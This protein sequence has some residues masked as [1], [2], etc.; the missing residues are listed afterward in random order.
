MSVRNLDKIFNPQRIAVVGASDEPGKVGFT[1][2]RN[3]IGAG[4]NGVVYPINPHREAVQGIHAYPTIA[5]L[6]RVPDLAIICTPAKTVPGLIRECGEAG[7]LGV[8]ILSAGFREAGEQGRELELQMREE[9]RQFD[10][11]R[12]IGPNC[13]GVMAPHVPLNASF[14]A[15]APQP[16]RIALISQS[17][18]LCTSLLDWA[19]QQNIGFS[20]FVSIGNMLDVGFGDLIDYFGED[21]HTQS[22]ILYVESI[23]DARGFMSAARSFARTKPIVAYKAGRFAESAQA[24]LSHTGAMAGEDA[25]CDAAFQR[26]GIERV[27]DMGEMFDC[28]ELLARQKLPRGPRLAIVTNAGGPGVMA[29]DTLVSLRGE[30]APLGRTT[31]ERLD[32]ALPAW[33]SHGNPIDVLGDAPPARYAQAVQV[34]L[35]DG[36]VDAAL[37]ILT[38]QAMTDPTATAAQVASVAARVSKPL[39]AAWIGGK[40]VREG[41]RLLS[42][43]GVPTYPTPEGAVNAFMHLVSYARN[44]E[45]LYETPRDVPLSFALDHTALQA[46]FNELL[47][48]SAD[49][50]SEGDS[51]S[52]FEV[53]GVSVARAIAAATPDEAARVAAEIGYPVVLK[54]LSPAITHKTDVG[55]VALD[56]RN[57]EGLRRAYALM[58]ERVRAKRPEAAI[59]GVTVQRM[60]DRTGGTELIVGMKKDATFGAV[61]MVGAGGI[62]A[63]LYRDRALGLP[64]LN[65]RLAHRMLS[66]LRSWPLLQGYRGRPRADLDRLIETLIRLSYLVAHHPEISE[67]DV[68]P[69]CVSAD[70][71]L[72]LD[73]RVV[74]DRRVLEHPVRPFAHL[75]IRPYPEEFVRRDVLADG[76][77]V[78]FRPIRPEDEPLWLELVAACSPETLHARFHY[79]FKS[80]THEVASRFVFLDYDRE[81]AIMAEIEDEGRKRFVG[82]GRLAA[83]ANHDTAE[84]AVLVADA[85]QNQGLGLKLIDNC[86]DIARCWG[87]KRIVAETTLGNPRMISIFETRG[88][89]VER[90]LRDGLVVVDKAL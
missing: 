27:F 51:K 80:P 2:L 18:A 62:T 67:F 44:L 36:Q 20:H 9:W 39:L 71:V 24:A 15:D 75:A 34:A 77:P 32:A 23:S 73:G 83:D 47:S 52:L 21:P 11:L 45:T 74:I 59:S 33:W 60:I 81:L 79:L 46:R 4:Y 87:V 70:E 29:T 8:V 65:E 90:N 37:A 3:V 66:G 57:E 89:R 22:I 17:G 86:L 63:E 78:T 19:A 50:L 38:P 54:I 85:W 56:I 1:L 16:G 48:R 88:F 58:L 30:L 13:L 31:L 12:I 43:A 76:R 64:P 61:M 42:E 7:V 53:Y 28:A 25:V 69:L 26:A 6:P 84:Y 55:G 40:R 68:N 41:D 82:V 72:A 49:V 10:G 35:A 5:A 14:A